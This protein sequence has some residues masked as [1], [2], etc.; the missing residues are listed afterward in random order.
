MKYDLIIVGAGILGVAHAYHAS[1]SGMKVL[2][3]EK[4]SFP[5]GSTVR[6]FGQVVPS[7]MSGKWFDY[8]IKSLKIYQ[9]IQQKFDISVTLLQR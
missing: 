5:V 3:L 4:D 9:E 7:G 8:G 6:N 2:I 1:K